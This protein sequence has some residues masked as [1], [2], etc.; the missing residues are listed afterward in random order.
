[1][2][3][4]P[5]LSSYFYDLKPKEAEISLSPRISVTGPMKKEWTLIF[6]SEKTNFTML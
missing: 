1:M 5:G 6:N 2:L 3:Q 4:G